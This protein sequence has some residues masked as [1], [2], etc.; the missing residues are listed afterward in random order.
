MPMMRRVS[1]VE[2]TTANEVRGALAKAHGASLGCPITTGTFTLI[3]ARAAAESEAERQ[4]VIT[5]Y[6]LTLKA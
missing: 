4:K 1:G 5:P 6:R 2:L 3:A